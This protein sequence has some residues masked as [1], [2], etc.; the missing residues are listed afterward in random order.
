MNLKDSAALLFSHLRTT[1]RSLKYRNYRL[2][3][4]GQSLSLIGTWM[5]QIAVSWLVYRLSGSSIALGTVAFAGQIPAFVLSPVGG[6]VADRFGRHRTLLVTQIL[7]M[8]QASALAFLVVSG[9]IEIWHLVLF[10][11]ILGTINAFDMPTRHA[12][13]IEM[14]ES[15]EDLGNAIAL[16]SSMFNGARLVGPTIAGV[17]IAAWGEGPCFVVNAASYT[18]VIASLVLMRFSRRRTPANTVHP[19]AQLKSGFDYAWHFAPIRFLIL[20]MGLMSLLGLPYIVLLPVFAREFLG[21]GSQTYGV[22]MGAAGVG[23]LAGALYMAAR[24]TVL[25]FGRLLVFAGLL[26]GAALVLFALSSILWLSLALL[27]C[28]GFGMMLLTAGCNTLLQTMV[29]DDK[30]GMVM[31]IYISAFIGLAPVGNLGAGFLAYHLGAHVTVLIGGAAALVVTGL[32]ALQLPALRERVRPVY[33]QKGI[34]PRVTLGL[35]TA[36]PLTAPPQD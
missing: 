9:H 6:V 18:A 2:F 12:F 27:V 34:L 15:P 26:F 36:A 31:S 11:T 14:I 23:A 3:F 7:S 16:N 22:M 30:R 17:I 28:A 1:F 24:K 21:G 32:F 29:D 10:N 4:G 19:L 25:G 8:V 13:V 5:Q 20:F 33:I 35:Q